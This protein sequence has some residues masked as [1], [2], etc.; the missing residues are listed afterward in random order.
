VLGLRALALAGGSG[1]VEWHAS[2]AGLPTDPAAF[3]VT[4]DGAPVA[5]VPASG[6]ILGWYSCPLSGLAEGRSYAV[7][8]APT[9]AAG[10][11]PAATTTVVGDDAGPG[12]VSGLSAALIS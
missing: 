10:A 9:N 3:A 7:A 1:R 4:L 6:G 12:P 8:V 11:G 5:T 2:P